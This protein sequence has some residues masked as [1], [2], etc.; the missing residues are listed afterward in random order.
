MFLALPTNASASV[1]CIS[2]KSAVAIDSKTCEILYEKNIDERMPVAS[3]TKIMTC[4][5]ACEMGNMDEIICITDKMLEG[6]EGSS[7]YLEVGDLIS[8]YDLVVGAML[9]SGND[10]ANAI[11]VH[12]SGSEDSFVDLMNQKAKKIGMQ[13]TRFATPSGLDA[14]K[15]YSTAYDMALLTSTALD[16]QMFA[17]VCKLKSAEI[18]V[19]NAPRTIY[20]HNKLLSYSNNYCGVKTGFTSKAGR[21]LASAYNHN[22]ATIIVVT[23]NAP[24][25]WEDHEQIVKLCS[26]KYKELCKTEELYIDVVGGKSAKVKCTAD[27]KITFSNNL[28]EKIYYY[29]FVYAPVYEGNTVGRIDYYSNGIKIESV[30]ITASESVELWQIMK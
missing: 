3:T 24:N 9:A 20:N 14:G 27:A 13:N 5:I 29:P 18:L 4:L 19:N 17:S 8:L 30:E 11:A 15:P 25:D 2:A 23:L 28:N 10:A 1:T 7:I 12:I 16:N 6:T 22:S 21:C 26:K